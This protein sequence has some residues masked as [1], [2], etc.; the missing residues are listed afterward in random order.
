MRHLA[1]ILGLHA[2][3]LAAAPRA[4]IRLPPGLT[5]SSIR[6]ETHNVFD[7]I[8]PPENKPLFRLANRAHRQTR[9]PV[10]W[11]ELLFEVGDRYDPALV[12]ETERNLRS[13]PFI[14]RAEAEATVNKKGTVDVIVRTYDSW[15][16]EVV[17]NFKRAGGEANWKAGLAEH[18]LL[19][20]GKTASMVYSRDG[21][22]SSKL[23]AWS[24]P[25]FLG[26]KHLVYSM[27]AQS[28]PGTRNYSLSLDSPFYAS[29]AR[30]AFGGTAS[31]SENIISLYS[32]GFAA[33]SARQQVAEVGINYGIAIA[34][35]TERTR[36]V[37]IGLLAHRADFQAT[38]DRPAGIIPG[39]KQ[40]VFLKIG[41][42]WEELD[43]ITVRRI[44]TFTRDEDYN[45]GFGVFPALAWSPYFRPFSTTESQILPSIVMRKGYSWSDNLLLLRSGYNSQYVNGGNGRRIASLQASYF[46]S[47]YSDQTL[48]VHAAF[49]HGWRLDPSAP[50]TLGE[51]NGL[52]GYGLNQF[53]GDR[54]LLFNIEDRLFLWDQLLR[55][56]DI[57]AVVFYDSGYVWPSSRS[58]KLADLKNSVG[59]GLRVAPTR[60]N[61][62]SPVRIDLA[63]ALSDNQSRSRWSLS[64]LAGQAFGP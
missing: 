55:L 20:W 10:I 62:N 34:T 61:N 59:L 5:I 50:L 4:A 51:V 13:L 17:A 26:K 64:I 11:R 32:G 54:R 12:A 42:D 6:I 25:Q 48:A 58:V 49:D 14:R 44:Q 40:L 56:F 29:I 57:G 23:F 21:S 15:T 37:K 16:F 28:A 36:H 60:S 1:L 39:E 9:D 41:G 52:R 45:L 7:T 33:G 3:P 19:G 8:T 63:Y 47:R 18:N 24:D 38:Y 35:S 30:S 53:S 22:E 46:M 2:A 27:R 43:F 31:Y